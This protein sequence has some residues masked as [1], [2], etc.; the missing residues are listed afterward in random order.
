[1]TYSL[2]FIN[3][4]DEIM[5]VCLIHELLKKTQGDNDV[6]K[7]EIYGKIGLRTYSILRLQNIFSY[8]E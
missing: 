3:S 2:V 8:K 7:F 6:S 5:V 1:M 4:K